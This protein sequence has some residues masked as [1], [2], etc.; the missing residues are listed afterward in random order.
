M[1]LVSCVVVR[2][3]RSHKPKGS[4]RCFPNGV[5][6]I[7]QLGFRKWKATSEG[8]SMP[9]NTSVFEHFGAFCPMQ[10]LTTL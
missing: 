1:T 9:E 4:K 6:Q 10:I 8:Q 7:P 2:H 3:E 5:F